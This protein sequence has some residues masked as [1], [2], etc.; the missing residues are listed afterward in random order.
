MLEQNRINVAHQNVLL[1]F[2]LDSLNRENHA[3]SL[4]H[5]KCSLGHTEV[6]ILQTLLTKTFKKCKRVLHAAFGYCDTILE[7]AKSQILKE[8]SQ[9]TFI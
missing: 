6:D 4:A 5:L 2:V 3:D 9:M 1:S 8:V 7:F